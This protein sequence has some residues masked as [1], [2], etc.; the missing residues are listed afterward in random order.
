[1][2][3]N[4][5]EIIL[6]T[7]LVLEREEEYSHRLIKAVLDKYN[8]LEERDKAFFKRVAE[9]SLERQLELDYYLSQYSKIPVK[10]MR[11][12]IRCLL[13]MSVYQ[14]LYM[15]SVPDSAVCNEAC[16]LAAKRGFQSLKGYVNGILRTIARQKEQ[17]P[18]PDKDKEP[19]RF[20]SVK[21]SMPEWLVELWLDEYGWQIT[22]TLLESLM[23]IHPVSLRFVSTMPEAKRK[24]L[25]NRMQ[26]Q[27]V[28]LFQSKYLP[29]VYLLKQLG[30]AEGVPALP[31]FEEGAFTVQDVSSALAVE[32]AGIREGDFVIDVCA[33]P[34][35]KSILAGEKAGSS[36]AFA[37]NWGDTSVQMQKEGA[38]QREE[39]SRQEGKP[40]QEE[41]TRQEGKP[42]QEEEIRQEGKPQQEEEIQQEGWIQGRVLARDISEEKVAF[43]E[44]NIHR[45]KASNIETEVFDAARTDESLVGKADVVLLDVPCSGLGVIGKKRDIKYH[46]TK[47][48]MASLSELQKQIARASA[49][50]VKPGGILLYSTCTIHREENQAMV[51]FFTQELDFVP[52]SLEDVLPDVALAQKKQIEKEMYKAGK[53]PAVKL[54][55][56]ENDACIQFLPGY[57]EAD[58]F[59]IAKFRRK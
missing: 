7:L 17:L 52:V 35:G 59:F 31:G 56:E 54:T 46:M 40:R 6:D 36:R 9:G 5:R 22:V 20:L 30:T 14:V 58:G 50:Y 41:E 24:E 27:G 34:G 26:K 10:K 32:A 51:R 29:Y 13:R 44:E 57:M 42:K 11:P 21:Y 53:E 48:K 4:I 28:Q 49:R 55:E 39:E 37:Q 2:T 8:Y 1:M 19:V 43:I 23:E 47:E 16:K 3:E 33:A 45:M 25:C 15:D 18:F 38:P 12:L